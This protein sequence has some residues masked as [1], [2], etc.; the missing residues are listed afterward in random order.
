MVHTDDGR[1]S[2]S[3]YV[4]GQPTLDNGELNEFGELGS[5]GLNSGELLESNLQRIS[6]SHNSHNS[7][8]K[9]APPE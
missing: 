1:W 5:N 8:L 4:C 7:P 6:D 2:D 3:V 9:E